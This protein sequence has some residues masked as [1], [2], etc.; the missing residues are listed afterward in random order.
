MSHPKNHLI[1]P[2]RAELQLRSTPP[3]HLPPNIMPSLGSSITRPNP[4]KK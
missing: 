2:K 3:A 1:T 4:T